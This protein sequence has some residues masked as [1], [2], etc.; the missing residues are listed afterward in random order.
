MPCTPCAQGGMGF[1][2]VGGAGLG[3]PGI[4]EDAV[5]EFE[6][7]LKRSFSISDFIRNL[8]TVSRNLSVASQRSSE[9]TRQYYLHRVKGAYAIKLNVYDR[10]RSS[11]KQ[12]ICQKTPNE[13]EPGSIH[14]NPGSGQERKY[15]ANGKP[16][17][18]I[19]WDHDHGQGVPHGHNWD[20]DDRG[21]GVP[22]SPWP[23][24]RKPKLKGQ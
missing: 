12:L 20:G 18:D 23:K 9:H 4:S 11:G 21:E 2:G 17:W 19:D 15:G 16:E 7:F 8:S 10:A 1:G 22:I 6:R 3:T 24:G 5:L 13:G 14:V